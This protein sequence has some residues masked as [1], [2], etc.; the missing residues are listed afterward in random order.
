MEKKPIVNEENMK[1]VAAG[2]DNCPLNPQ[3][4]VIAPQ[5]ENSSPANPKNDMDFGIHT[6]N[7]LPG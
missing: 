5:L 6:N 2:A 7:G 4:S 1:N 3:A